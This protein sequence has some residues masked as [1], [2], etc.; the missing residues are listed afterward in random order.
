MLIKRYLG[1]LCIMVA[2]IAL[3]TSCLDSDNETSV[4]LY[5][6]TAITAFGLTS[7]VAEKHTV[8]S[9]G[10]DSVY[11]VTDKSV[12]AYPFYIDHLKGEIYNVDSL[13]H[14]TDITRLLCSVSTKNSGSVVIENQ[15]RDSTKALLATDS[16]D[17][18]EPRH[19]RAYSSDMRTYREYA[20][21][22]VKHSE[23]GNEFVWTRM[24][25]NTMLAGLQAVKTL[26][27]AGRIVAVGLQD[28][29]TKIFQT[30]M[31]DG[32]SWTM[33][34]DALPADIYNNVAQRGDTLFAITGGQMV[35]SLDGAAF[36]RFADA[37][38]IK[39]LVGASTC[40]MYAIG[41]DGSMMVSANGGR[42][43]QTDAT[44]ATADMLPATDV[45]CS[46]S[47]FGFYDDTDYVI[48]A[49]NRADGAAQADTCAVVWR[50]I[51]PHA[52]EQ[53]AKWSLVEGYRQQYALPKM[54]NICL[55]NYEKGSV[56][57]FG[58]AGF[59]GSTA[60]PYSR[61]Y[62]SGDGGITWK[63]SLS[64]AFPTD[65]N[66]AAAECRAVVDK[67][68]NIWLVSAGTGQVYRGK[69]NRMS[70]EDR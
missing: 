30:D 44:D 56:L 27:L 12:S 39:T 26:A 65:F 22:V 68:N 49:G 42:T 63:H 48:M 61:I 2:A 18:T 14:Y 43:W 21:T 25:D 31:A 36:S 29:Y 8:S 32:N 9:K 67:N 69:L 70:W 38:Q 11:Y 15:A 55:L 41:T 3:F 59:G 57:A 16:I 6:D 50:K 17:F 4:T 64:Y 35:I 40:E 7:S 66:T 13:P 19:V 5:G 46:C 60:K 10:E 37:G 58:G 54:K 34:A 45:A 53:S 47:P 28:G 20:I 33:T 62:E 52:A 24:A 51:V 1:T 23:N